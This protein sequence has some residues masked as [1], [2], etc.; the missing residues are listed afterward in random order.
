MFNK[1]KFTHHFKEV[2][3]LTMSKEK[4]RIGVRELAERIGVSAST[5]SRLEKGKVPDVDTFL[6]VCKWMGSSP[7]NYMR[8]AN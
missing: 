1:E 7:V 6:R 4:R 2:I 8:N 5:V 3:F